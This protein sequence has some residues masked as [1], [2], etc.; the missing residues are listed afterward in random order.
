MSITLEDFTAIES[1]TEADLEELPAGE[2]DDYEYKS[3]LIATQSNYRAELADKITKTASAF[4]NTGGVFSLW[5]WM[6]KAKWM[7][8]SL[9]D[10]QDQ[11]T[12]LGRPSTDECGACWSL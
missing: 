11:P 3:S 6:T 2:S 9:N 1:W 4:W 5:V 8:V 12:R 10:G 7:V